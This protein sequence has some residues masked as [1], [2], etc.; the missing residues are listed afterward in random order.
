MIY[1]EI[2]IYNNKKDLKAYENCFHYFTSKEKNVITNMGFYFH[3]FRL[4]LYYLYFFD[5]INPKKNIT[6]YREIMNQICSFGGDTDTNAAIVGTVIGPLIGFKNFGNK[7]LLTM[8][9]L[10]PKKRLVY[11][12][13]LMILYVHYLRMNKS[14]NE[15]RKNFL[16]MI[17]KM[18]LEKIDVKNLDSVF[19]L[20]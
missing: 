7:E 3:A 20:N 11:S 12:P 8:V 16:L 2:N 18:M 15:K 14:N 4:T 17:L 6:K 13:G 19:S 10:V 5:E 1:E 9:K